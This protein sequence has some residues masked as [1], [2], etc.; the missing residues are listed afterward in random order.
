M[1]VKHHNQLSRLLY[2]HDNPVTGPRALS[3]AS[4]CLGGSCLFFFFCL[5]SPFSEM[6]VQVFTLVY[7]LQKRVRMC[8]HIPTFLCSPSSSMFL[9]RCGD[10]SAGSNSFPSKLHILFP[11]CK[12]LKPDTQKE[13]CYGAL[14]WADFIPWLKWWPDSHESW[15]KSPKE[16][17]P[18]SLS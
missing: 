1:L 6:E 12:L 7:S 15:G 3:L 13:L 8:V 10:L 17:R 9:F 11:L 14:L 4:T 2:G 5:A 16:F 18:V